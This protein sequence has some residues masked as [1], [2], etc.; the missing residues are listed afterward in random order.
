MELM[1]QYW[2][3]KIP[4]LALILSQLN[5]VHTITPDSFKISSNI[6]LPFMPRSNKYS[7]TFRFYS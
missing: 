5:S 4:P 1:G 3:H 7:L 6:T 2:V